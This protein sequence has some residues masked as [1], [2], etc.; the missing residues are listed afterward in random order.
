MDFLDISYSEIIK[1]LVAFLL[2]ALLGLEREYHNK[3]AGFR[4]LIMITIGA[5]L[6]TIVS[7]RISTT[8]P[9]RIAANIVT[10]I[11]FIGAGVIFKAGMK[12]GGI[13]T[14][15]TIWVA[16][17][18]GMAVGYGAFYLAAFVTIIILIIL[19][20]LTRLETSFD[21]LR[22]SRLYKIVYLK[23]EYSNTL[24]EEKF[25]LLKIEF[26]K[27][28][29]MK[30]GGRVIVFYKI[31]ANQ[32]KFDELNSFLMQSSEVMGFDA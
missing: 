10:G 28:K 14:A 20:L 1:I 26:I 18:I 4:T 17:A 25:S 22:Q 19:L 5:T 24:L 3:S 32:L 7:Y 8:T 30:M 12:V 27:N 23:N 11:G 13:T 2:G 6:F 29:E 9:D 21:K 15:A 16:A 31:T